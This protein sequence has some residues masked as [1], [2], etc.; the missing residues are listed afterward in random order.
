[1]K[2]KLKFL[3][4]L[5]ALLVGGNTS[6]GSEVYTVTS[7]GTTIN[8]STGTATFTTSTTYQ[9]TEHVQLYVGSA[10]TI[11]SGKI[12]GT[13]L[14]TNGNGTYSYS[15]Y[16]LP[17][18]GAYLTVTPSQNGTLVL[19]GSKNS[20]GNKYLVIQ[21]SNTSF[22]S[23][24]TVTC[25]G[26]SCAWRTD[27]NGYNV[28][29]TSGDIVATLTVQS[30]T[31][32]YIIFDSFSDW[33]FTG[34][35]FTKQKIDVADADFGFMYI[36]RNI[37]S[38]E[39]YEGNPLV[40]RLN[41]PVTYSSSNT[42]AATINSATGETTIQT[43]S[44]GIES[45]TI[46]A[47][48][49]GN[50]DYNAK[51]ATY[52]LN[53]APAL[54]Y[55]DIS[56][57]NL[58]YQPGIN[59]IS[60]TQLN[61]SVGGFDLTFGENEGI[62]CNNTNNFYF[63]TNGSGA[64]GSMTIALDANNN[65]GSNYIKKIVFTAWGTPSLSVN[66]VAK[67]SGTLTQTGASEWTWTQYY[68]NVNTVTFTSQGENDESILI[69]NVRVYTNSLPTFTK[70]TPIPGFNRN[71]DSYSTGTSVS[72]S[73]LSISTTPSYFLFDY[74]FNAGSTGLTHTPYTNNTTWP[75]SITG[76]VDDGTATISANFN[77]GT[78]P[79]F[80][81]VASTTVYTLTVSS[82]ARNTFIWNFAK[83]LSTIDQKLL[84]AA[85]TP[86][87]L[88]DGD[89]KLSNGDLGNSTTPG[90]FVQNG[91]ELE[92]VYGL[93]AFIESN[94]NDIIHT[95][96]SGFR[97]DN[98]TGLYIRIPNLK[99]GDKIT[100]LCN[101]YNDNRGF[102]CPSNIVNDATAT[103]WGLRSKGDF[104]C[105]GYVRSDGN[106]DL[107]GTSAFTIKSITV[108]SI[109]KPW[110][111]LSFANGSSVNVEIPYNGSALS[112]TNAL[113]SV[114]A[115]ATATYAILLDENGGGANAASIN[116]STGELTIKAVGELIVRATTTAGTYNSAYYC[117]YILNA[118]QASEYASWTYTADSKEIDGE[119][120]P[121]Q[122]T[123]TFTSS[124]KI[125]D[126]N[127]V[128]TDVPGITMKMGADGEVWNVAQATFTKDA[129]TWNLGLAAHNTEGANRPTCTTGCYFDFT[130]T[131]NGELTVNYYTGERVFLYKNNNNST[132]N[133]EQWDDTRIQTKSKM[134]IAGNKYTLVSTDT[135][136]YL[137]SFT[138]RPAFLTPDETAEQT[139]TFEANSSTTEFPKLVHEDVGVRFSGN[140]AVVNLQSDGGVTLVGGGTAVIRGKVLSGNNSLTAYYTLV[141]N[142]LSVESTTPAN[143]AT[144]TTLDNNSFYVQF[145]A[146]ISE[147]SIDATKVVVLKDAETLTDITVS[148][149]DNS[150]PEYQKV[151]KISNFPTPLE[152]GSTYT[153]RIMSECVAKD[154]DATVKNPE[155]IGTFI[156]ESTEPPLTWFYP[157][158]TSAVRIGTS[159]VL[160]TNQKIDEH[161]PAGGIWGKL[162][163]EG[164]EDEDY[165]MLIKAM[166]DDNKIVFKPSKPLEPNKLYTLTVEANQVK[167]NGS[168]NMITKDKVFLF[169]TGTGTGAAPT[170]TGKNSSEWSHSA[171]TI[172]LTFNVNI[173]LEPY[174]TISLTPIN[175]NE[176]TA[177]G[178]SAKLSDSGVLTGSKIDISGNELSFGFSEDELKYDLW[179]RLVLPANTV[180][181]PGG[182]PN[183]KDYVYEFKMD[184]K[185]SGQLVTTAFTGYPYTWDFTKI[186]QLTGTLTALATA[187]NSSSTSRWQEPMKDNV[188]KGYYSNYVNANTNSGP[189][190]PQ[191]EVASYNNG[192]NV[193]IPDMAGLRWSLV[194][195]YGSGNDRMQIPTTGTSLNLVGG[196]HYLTIPNVPA[197]KLYIKARNQEK[198]DINTPGVTFIQGGQEDNTKGSVDNSQEQVFIINVPE[199]K[200]VSFC[201][202]DVN[203]KMIAV[204][205][206]E[207]EISS[208]GYATNARSYP[209]D[210]TLD[211]TLLGTGVTAYKIT[212]VSGSSVVASPVT[213]VPATTTTNQYN[214]V[215][216]HGSEGSWPLFTLD[217][218]STEETLK[219]NKLIGVVSGE[220]T[221][222]LDQK[223]GSNYNYVL[224]NGG[225]TVKYETGQTTGKVVGEAS[226]VGFYLLLKDGTVLANNSTYTKETPNDYTAYLQLG[227]QYVMHTEVG[228]SSARQFFSIDFGDETTDIKV[229]GSDSSKTTSDDAFYSLQGVRLD[230]PGKGIYIRNGK[231]V[232][233]K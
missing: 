87:G 176:P 56:V 142:V 68:D 98:K 130:P 133:Y 125:D 20:G 44:S 13:A 114:P 89:W 139:A 204:A 82:V 161:Y 97:F 185:S 84:S 10:W 220:A 191:G 202:Q 215:M 5:L 94:S 104:T 219:D 171:G 183:S 126:T 188:S 209:V 159:I 103:G 150:Y 75:G 129:T 54:V 153:I 77:D 99:A 96:G 184:P 60:G 42:S 14:P 200:D 71:S 55:T 25:S 224:S 146:N 231:M 65:S 199:T 79:F 179:Y 108:E 197:G 216:L 90:A 208:V 3:W 120:R 118:T 85:S 225:Y 172:R 128:I 158:T 127:R 6:W 92:Y 67:T 30:G 190:F 38:G 41:L 83:S 141:S 31:T 152:A 36:Y 64:K 22:I 24:A 21:T 113:T 170:V 18:G 214:G 53:V 140:R 218:N 164:C 107:S 132:G 137:H 151:L 86:W 29:E 144:I 203:F 19:N 102:S 37:H 156:V 206:Q 166:K 124:G 173:E 117:D 228:V 212:G 157:T 15:N 201:L 194:K 11:S 131:V 100:V 106:V 138:F 160:K 88:N 49:A 112:Y 148:R 61:R 115:G 232:V 222:A 59:G 207:K 210:Y 223:T 122:G 227:E 134:L 35:T 12:T 105:V 34:F 52:S 186:G 91:I 229:I 221:G 50:D 196:T 174:S 93:Q 149:A 51:D 111:S 72:I 180:T 177:S 17:T 192:T 145:S 175:G 217:V 165:P 136:L 74:T 46:T 211:E 23:N 163:Y 116:A 45:T 4:V 62:K 58:R 123:V 80:N 181:G 178:T 189:F 27:R 230:N 9:A 2:T 205:T 162:T 57:A 48:F 198:F 70:V 32:Y 69:S 110:P 95:N 121:Y 28:T 63:R 101:N 233:V 73:D 155:Y 167:Y 43:V 135:N 66:S 81:T 76:T 168:T 119:S 109:N 40:N 169:T 47:H 182:M 213:K 78:N 143:G 1:M 39:P 154:G 16:L 147:S 226:G 195:Y 193:E 26:N 187:K 33:S 7:D 8:T